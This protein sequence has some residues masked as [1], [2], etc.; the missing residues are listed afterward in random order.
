MSAVALSSAPLLH[1]HHEWMT[2][3]ADERFTSL[4][5]LKRAVTARADSA[6]TIDVTPD[7]LWITPERVELVTPH[8]TATPTHWAFGQLTG[9]LGIPSPYL[10][11]LPPALASACLTHGLA[12]HRE[13]A[14]RLLIHADASEVDGFPMLRAITSPMY[15]RIWDRDVVT[16][17]EHLVDQTGGRFFNPKDWSGTPSGLYASDRDVFLFFI[18]GGSVVEGGGDRDQLHRGF[19]VWN[20]EV[21]AATFGI[22]VF[23]FRAVCGNHIVWGP[24]EYQEVRIRHSSRAPERFLSEAAPLLT[25]CMTAS[26]EPIEAQVRRAKRLEL[27]IALEDRLDWLETRGLTR[28]E[29][30]AG[31][32]RADEEEGQSITLWNLVNGVSAVARTLPHLDAKVALE[33]K[34]GAL[35]AYAA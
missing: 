11:T 8:G 24:T 35:L 21:G 1:A 14:W 34:A 2:R 7:Q 20:S 3:P 6:D 18:D 33:R 9:Q 23:L 5:A 19:F 25:R 10:R 30:R 16:F 31:V 12:T 28:P 32:V 15:G 4:D 22:A 13:Q 17:V 29:A 26:A 27:P